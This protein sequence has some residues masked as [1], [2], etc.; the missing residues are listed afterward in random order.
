MSKPLEEAYCQWSDF[1][2][3]R[4][5]YIVDENNYE[6][7]GYKSFENWSAQDVWELIEDLADS[8]RELIHFTLE[9]QEKK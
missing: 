4:A 9:K 2:D 5:D 3:W 8:V 6:N 7:F 1:C